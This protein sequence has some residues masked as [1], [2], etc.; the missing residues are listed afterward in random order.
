MYLC[1]LVHTPFCDRLVSQVTGSGLEDRSWI[2]CRGRRIFLSGHAQ[3]FSEAHLPSY[4][5]DTIRGWG[6]LSVGVKGPEHEPHH[7]PPCSA[8]VQNGWSSL[9]TPC[10]RL[11]VLLPRHGSDFC[12]DW[13]FLALISILS[14]PFFSFSTYFFSS[15]SPSERLCSPS[16]LLLN[17]HQ[18]LLIRSK[19]ART[20][21]WPLACI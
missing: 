3:T 4:S 8:G 2:P 11:H 17:E 1:R 20:W 5:M 13:I 16:S 18:G 14:I 7:W 9:S 21:S 6:A 10:I 19:A 12:L 15:P